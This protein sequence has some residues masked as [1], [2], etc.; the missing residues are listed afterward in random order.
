M[1][2]DIGHLDRKSEASTNHRMLLPE[3]ARHKIPSVSVGQG[4]V[5]AHVFHGPKEVKVSI[6]IH[7]I[8][9]LERTRLR[10]PCDEHD[11]QYYGSWTDLV[12]RAIYEDPVVIDSL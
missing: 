7:Y 6:S 3:P 10:F 12:E 5:H 8:Y 2:N 4:V 1:I 9:C 11:M